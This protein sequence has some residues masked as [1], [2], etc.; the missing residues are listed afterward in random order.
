M[1]D[2]NFNIFNFSPSVKDPIILDTD[3]KVTQYQNS[4]FSHNL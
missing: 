4:W 3:E 2:I 1:P